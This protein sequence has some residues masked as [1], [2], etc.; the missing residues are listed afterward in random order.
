MSDTEA[1]R[2]FEEFLKRPR[3]RPAQPPVHDTPDRDDPTPPPGWRPGWTPPGWERRGDT[4]VE[5]QP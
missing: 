2:R 1:Y 3:R 4:W 5:R